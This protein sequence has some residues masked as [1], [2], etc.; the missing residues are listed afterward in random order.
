MRAG[1]EAWERRL[2]NGTL[3]GRRDV[4]K[5]HQRGNR[6]NRKPKAKRP[7]TPAVTSPVART[8]GTDGVKSGAAKKGR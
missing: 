8:L 4:A 2:D 5:R 6:E 7:K 3:E 1:P